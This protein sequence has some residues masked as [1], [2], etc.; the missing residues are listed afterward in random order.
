MYVYL[1]HNSESECVK[2]GVANDPQSRLKDLQVGSPVPLAILQTI[3]CVSRPSAHSLEKLL[4]KKYAAYRVSG[5]W[6]KIDTAVL[7]AEIS[8]LIA[9]AECIQSPR[10]ER[11]VIERII[12]KPPIIKTVEKVIK[13]AGPF[14]GYRSNIGEFGMLFL[15]S[16]IL[17]VL[18]LRWQSP[19]WMYVIAILCCGYFAASIVAT[20]YLE[21][22]YIVLLSRD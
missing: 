9:I 2:I 3:E 20:L 5:E 22:K 4:H 10:I 11:K 14:D 8:E 12:E 13:E 19:H 1:I 16:L 15:C 7:M 18:L 6:F 17:Y 21:H